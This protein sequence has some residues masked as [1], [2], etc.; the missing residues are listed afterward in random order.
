MSILIDESTRVLAQG[1][2]GV[3][4]RRDARFCLDYG[5]KIVCGVTP[6]K[7]GETVYDLPVYDSVREALARHEIDASIIYAPPLRTKEAILE[8]LDA[9]VKTI[10]A[11]AEFVPRHD[12]AIIRAAAEAAGAT[13]IGCNTNGIISA[14][15]S[16]LGAIG[17]DD[18]DEVFAPGRIGVC[19]RSGGMSAEFGLTLR[20]ARLG[21]STCVSMGGDVIPGTPMVR[22]VEMFVNDPDTDAIVIFGEPG[23]T[24]EHEVAAF[25]R[26]GECSKPLVALLAGAFQESYPKGVSFGHVAAM[27]QA[28]EDSVTAKRRMLAEAGALVAHTLGDVPRLIREALGG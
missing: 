25:L 28:D 20:R 3:Q 14:S 22:Y 18:P 19:S 21:V 12:T 4:G 8:A 15:K 5:T 2:T 27:I 17:G 13:V 1:L 23:T 9:G 26:A 16:K 10:C 11:L 24:A 7:G 6:G